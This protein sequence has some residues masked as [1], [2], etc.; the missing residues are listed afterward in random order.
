MERFW[1][2]DFFRG[3]AVILMI[4]FN[5]AFALRYFGIYDLDLG[6]LFWWLFPRLIAGAFIFIAG[7]SLAVSYSRLKDRKTSYRKYVSRGLVVFSLGLLITLVTFFLVPSVF[8]M[9]GILH[10]IGAAVMLSPLFLKLGRKYILVAALSSLA[11]GIYL[12]GFSVSFP[13]LLWL[14]FIPENFITLDYFP[15]L[16]W[17]G[18]FLLGIYFSGVLYKN[19]RRSFKISEQPAVS[20][21]VCLLGRN[22]LMIYML[23]QPLLAIAL[24]LLNYRIF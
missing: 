11:A 6:F 18:V 16:P 8:V 21:L 4:I 1:E 10:F 9:F 2:I 24:L 7:L 19:G 17:L 15:L 20:R 5:Y 13:W 14:G 22:S 3:S 12:Q 23:H